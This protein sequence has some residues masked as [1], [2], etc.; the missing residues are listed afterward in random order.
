MRKHRQGFSRSGR[1]GFNVFWLIILILFTTMGVYGKMKISSHWLDD[2]ITIDGQMEDWKGALVYV[3]NKGISL[4]ILNDEDH[5]ALCVIVSDRKILMQVMGR[6]LA[7]WFDPSGKT[8]K[9]RGIKFPIGASMEDVGG[10]MRMGPPDPDRI[11]DLFQESL[12]E[13]EILENGEKNGYRYPLSSLKGLEA[14]AKI[15]HGLMVCELRIPLQQGQNE[16]F[17]IGWNRDLSL[18]ICLE[19]PKIEP[20][21]R[22]GM[23]PGSGGIPT[24]GMPGGRGGMR[25]GGR[26][27]RPPGMDFSHPKPLKIKARVILATKNPGD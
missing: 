20:P 10:G 14:C 23:G 9:I 3:K 21:D 15:T 27:M 11:K 18:T 6:G 7:I 5:L 24:G 25:G 8:K 16:L 13:I 17:S 4:G 22:S 26:G 12:D 19:T 1:S 2:G